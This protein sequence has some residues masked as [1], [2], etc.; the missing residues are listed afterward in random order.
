MFDD[1]K[2]KRILCVSI[3][4]NDEL[5]IEDNTYELYLAKPVYKAKLNECLKKLEIL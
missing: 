4:A 2:I 5:S 1:N 3:S